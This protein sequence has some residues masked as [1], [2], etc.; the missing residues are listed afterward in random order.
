MESKSTM[1]PITGTPDSSPAQKRLD[2]IDALRALG[3]VYIVV[4]HLTLI[5]IPNLGV[6]TWAS[7]IILSGGTGV[8]LFFILSAFTL[9]LSMR[10]REREPRSTLSFYG[11]RIFR[12]APLFYIWIIVSMI[13]DRLWFGASH[14]VGTVLLSV[15]FGFNLVPGQHEGFVWAS[16]ILGVEMLFYLIFPIVYRYIDDIWK[17]VGFFFATVVLSGGFSYW[18]TNVMGMDPVIRDSYI[19][20]NFF[21]QLPVFALGMVVYYFFEQYILNTKRPWSWSFVCLTASALLYGARLDGRMGFLWDD[22]Y[23]QALIYG[24]LLIGLAIVPVKLLVNPVSRFLGEISY[25]IYLNH[26]TFIFAF[27][28]IYRTIYSYR[29]PTTL[30]FGICLFLTLGVVVVVSYLTYQFIERPGIRVGGW[31]IKRIQQIRS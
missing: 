1:S 26:P 15:F 30:Q 11:R 19:R 5:P 28:P 23:W 7:K 9:T 16:W 4:Y 21:H 10:K 22:L 31:I 27:I 3:A 25:S 6:P 18:I 14:S 20:F 2:F 24:A 13:R 17:S 8:T 12:I 29:I